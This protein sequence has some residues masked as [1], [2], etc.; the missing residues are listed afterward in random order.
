[1][2]P[3]L[4]DGVLK[5]R[6]NTKLSICCFCLAII[7][8][9]IGYL[10]F[11]WVHYLP[12]S[13]AVSRS[14]ALAIALAGFAAMKVDRYRIANTSGFNKAYGTNFYWQMVII[15]MMIACVA[16]FDK[17]TL[18]TENTQYLITKAAPY[19]LALLIVLIVFVNL[20]H[21]YIISQYGQKVD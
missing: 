2:E 12:I 11:E 1:M 21:K 7:I 9:G 5:L 15:A 14:V 18:L 17:L 13:K 19:M 10:P 4:I 8:V 20:R 6:R 16:T 3:L